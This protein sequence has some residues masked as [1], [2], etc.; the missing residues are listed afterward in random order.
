M[1][2]SQ[3]EKNE[4]FVDK[5][6][7]AIITLAMTM[8]MV[9]S[10]KTTVLAMMEVMVLTMKT[11]KTMTTATTTATTVT[12]LIMAMFILV[13]QVSTSVTEEQHTFI[14]TGVLDPRDN[15]TKLDLQT[16]IMVGVVDQVWDGWSEGGR[17]KREASRE[18]KREGRREEWRERR[19]VG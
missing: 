5:G 8:T 18:G 7:K 17:R 12:T 6:V 14:I 13:L 2:K 19:G 16:A 3:K 1:I 11:M 9:A 10:T 15:E 4:E